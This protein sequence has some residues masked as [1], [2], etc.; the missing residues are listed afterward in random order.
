MEILERDLSLGGS[1]SPFLILALAKDV[2]G[3]EQ[4]CGFPIGKKQPKLE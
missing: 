2:V 1:I 3:G 4:S